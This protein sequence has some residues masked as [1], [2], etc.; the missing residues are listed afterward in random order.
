MC[1]RHAMGQTRI[2]LRRR[3]FGVANRFN[4]ERG[5]PGA[6]QLRVSHWKF[7]QET[8]RLE[9]VF[10]AQGHQRKRLIALILPPSLEAEPCGT[11]L[12]LH[13]AQC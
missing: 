12:L 9:V 1:R 13:L 10:D 5:G 2:E 8:E 6:R 4:S 11:A 3:I 7:I